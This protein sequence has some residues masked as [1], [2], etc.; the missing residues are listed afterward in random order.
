[1]MQGSPSA[2]ERS[3]QT[4]LHVWSSVVVMCFEQIWGLIL[5]CV[6]VFSTFY[7]THQVLHTIV[8]CSNAEGLALLVGMSEALVLSICLQ[9]NCGVQAEL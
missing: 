4:I 8:G 6:L 3:C 1:M 5:S 7:V 9:H 2:S